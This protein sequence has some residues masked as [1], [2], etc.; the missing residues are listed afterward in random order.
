[1][2]ERSLGYQY[3]ID[4]FELDVCELFVKM[5]LSTES[6]KKVIKK[7][8]FL[9]VSIPKSRVTISDT[10]QS[11]LL[12][13]LREEGVNLEVLKAFFEK[14]DACEM[15]KLV[16]EHPTGARHRRIWMLYEKLTNKCLDISDACVGNYIA[17]LDCQLQL[18]LPVQSACRERRYRINNNLI[19]DF[20]F[21]PYVR[22]TDEIK[23]LTGDKLKEKADRLLREYPHELIYRAV[24]YMFVKE[25]RSSFAIE[26]ETP[27]QKRMESFLTVLREIPDGFV[28]EGMLASIQNR[29]VDPRYR[30]QVWRSD[31]VYVGETITPG[32]E[33]VHCIGVRPKDL[34][35]VMDAY[36][37][38]VNNRL[39]KKDVDAVML[40]AIISFA[41]V[42]IHPFDDGN[43]RLHRYLM[44]YVLSRLDFTPKDF[45]FP[46]SAVL[47]KKSSEYDKMLESFSRRLMAIIDYD[48]DVDGEVRVLQESAD[49]YRYIDYTPIVARF[50]SIMNETIQTEWKAELDYLKSYD[51]IRKAMRE[52]VDLPEKKANQFIMF[53]RNNNG[54]L[55]KTKR[56]KF[57]ELSD[58][59]IHAL[60]ATIRLGL[61]DGKAG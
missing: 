24:K 40:A 8:D 1:M 51:Q 47:L 28:T 18:A 12:F 38:M 9:T 48:I 22:F 43:G 21:S 54:V 2:I 31:Q 61:L 20:R 3:L 35:A 7:D 17:L 37:T 60:E 45:V 52:I 10:W 29:V 55:S 42:F 36:L 49:Y 26:R 15:M 13:A 5:Y 41:F 53:V 6:Q 34:V 14:I 19:G 39:E 25:T 33:K 32:R 44:H 27:T 11:N 56:E 16:S 59:E 57:S 30:Q 50:L 46:V 58:D 23:A 4:K